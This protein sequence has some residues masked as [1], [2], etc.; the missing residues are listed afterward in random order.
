MT[1]THWKK[2]QNPDFIGAYALEEN[3]DLVL[4]IKSIRQE[5][6]KGMDGKE[7]EGLIARFE[8]DVKPMIINATNAKMITKLYK[9]PYIEEWVGKKIQVYASVVRAF[10]E[11]VEALR[12]RDLKPKVKEID[13]KE[14]IKKL[15]GAKTQDELK[16]AYLSLSKGEQSHPEVIKTK[17]EMKG[18]VK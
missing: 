10:G 4:T 1:K 17:D 2:T 13:P 12:I 9:T 3:Q 18:M 16:T 8:E 5:K 11:D 6:F 15:K 7:D 14:A